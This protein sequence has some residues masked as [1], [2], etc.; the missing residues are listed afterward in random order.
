M[1]YPVVA[2][3]MSM[4]DLEGHSPVAS[5]S[6]CDFSFDCAAVNNILTDMQDYPRTGY[7]RAYM[8]SLNFDKSSNILKTVQ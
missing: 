4:N 7:F 2:F 3:P 1:A 8:T 6:N 5:H